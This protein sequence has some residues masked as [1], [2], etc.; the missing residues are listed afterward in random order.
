[1]GAAGLSQLLGE[2]GCPPALCEGRA[3]TILRHALDI[4]DGTGDDDGADMEEDDG[5]GDGWA[6]TA[7]RRQQPRFRLKRSA[8]LREGV[9]FHSR[10]LSTLPAEQEVVLIEMATDEKGRRCAQVEAVTAAVKGGGGR[11][12]YEAATSSA[13]VVGWIGLD[14]AGGAHLL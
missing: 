7:M 10:H 2:L 3:A 9:S 4:I 11:E 13:A 8:R 12:N 5:D 1:M 14:L 6:E